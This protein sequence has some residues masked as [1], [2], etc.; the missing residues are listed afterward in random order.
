[1]RSNNKFM[2]RLLAAAAICAASSN[3]FAGSF[4]DSLFSMGEKPQVVDD[5][6]FG[7]QKLTMGDMSFNPYKTSSTGS[8][9]AECTECNGGATYGYN[10]YVGDG[11]SYNDV[12]YTT[13]AYGWTPVRPVVNTVRVAAGPV[14][15]ALRASH[16]VVRGVRNFLFGSYDYCKPAYVCDPCWNVCDNCV[17]CDTTVASCDT[18]SDCDAGVVV[19]QPCAPA[20]PPFNAVVYAPRS[21]CGYGYYPG[22]VN[23]L[24]PTTGK[25]AVNHTTGESRTVDVPDLDADADKENTAVNTTDA[26]QPQVFGGVDVDEAEDQGDLLDTYKSDLKSVAPQQPAPALPADS[27]LDSEEVE[28][29]PAVPATGAGVIRMLVPADSVVYVNGYRTKQKGEVR[30][31]AAKNLEVG[32]NY[33]FDIQVVAVRNGKTFVDSKK[34]TLTAGDSTALAFNLTETTDAFAL[35]N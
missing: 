2:L 24:D 33:S 32:E 4:E 13:D 9:Y 26:I 10:S 15:A 5:S 12:V 34:V 14:R 22:Q 7:G 1:M 19:G 29:I 23:A 11:Y 17:A 8:V 16:N 6:F 35:N 30:T 18:C 20:C 3:A 28:E 25:S 21:C 31:F 27:L